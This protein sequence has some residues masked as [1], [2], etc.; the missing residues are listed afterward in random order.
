[1]NTRNERANAEILKV[2][3][4]I[5]QNKMNDPRLDG[6]ITIDK[7][8]CTPDFKYCKV[9]ISTLELERQ[10]E[11]VAVLKKSEGFIK[12]NLASMLDMP[13]IPKLI[14]VK[15]K[16]AENTIRVQELLKNIKYS[17]EA[18]DEE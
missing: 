11:V 13:Y 9:F 6:V 3:T 7:V 4:E 16:S 17:T 1:M 18:N 15:D 10:D 8:E 12:K 14:F 5:I 2:L